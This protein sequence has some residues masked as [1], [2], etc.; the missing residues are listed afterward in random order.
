MFQLVLFYY[1]GEKAHSVSKQSNKFKQEFN[2]QDQANEK[3][4]CTLQVE[5]IKRRAKREGLKQI[6]ET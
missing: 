5:K 6:E 2:L 3:A 1:A 4:T